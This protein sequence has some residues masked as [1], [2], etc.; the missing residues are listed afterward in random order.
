M[1]AGCPSRTSG[2]LAS[3][4]S[5]GVGPLYPVTGVISSI[6]V[7]RGTDFYN[8]EPN[9]ETKALREVLGCDAKLIGMFANGA[10]LDCEC[11]E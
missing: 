1:N 7:G 2:P 5:S 11:S 9:V 4:A 6:C 3:P 10:L 8:G